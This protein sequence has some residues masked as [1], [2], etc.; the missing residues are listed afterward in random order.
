MEITVHHALHLEALVSS[1]TSNSQIKQ[2]KGNPY[3]LSL[4]SLKYIPHLLSSTVR[5]GNLDFKSLIKLPKSLCRG[6]AS[7]VSYK[8]CFDSLSEVTTHDYE[9]SL[10]IRVKTQN[11]SE[12]LTFML[13][14]TEQSGNLTLS[15][16]A[17]QICCP[18]WPS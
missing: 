7:L 9:D 14:S 11:H 10:L 16:K 1:L 13:C 12:G 15:K 4:T 8:G 6:L 5:Y 2:L 18:T 3:W 17:K